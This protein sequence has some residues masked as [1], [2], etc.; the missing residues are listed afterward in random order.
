MSDKADDK[1]KLSSDNIDLNGI[2][3]NTF[4]VD[5]ELLH[6]DIRESAEKKLVRKLDC[7]LMPTI[8]VI[9]LMNYIDVS[10]PFVIHDEITDLSLLSEQPLV[11]QG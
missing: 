1:Q 5:G 3:L 7:R 6:P 11:L 4:D 9:Y 8:I 10:Q 2:E